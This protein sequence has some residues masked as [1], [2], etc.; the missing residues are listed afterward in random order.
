MKPR[1]TALGIVTTA[2]RGPRKLEVATGP[3]HPSLVL[4]LLALAALLLAISMGVKVASGGSTTT[5]PTQLTSYE[6]EQLEQIKYLL[7]LDE[8]DGGELRR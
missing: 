8:T 3:R 4:P 2:P 1:K 7:W 6:V 5:L